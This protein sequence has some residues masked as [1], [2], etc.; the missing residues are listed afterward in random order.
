[1]F[2]PRAGMRAFLTSLCC[3]SAGCQTTST[4]ISALFPRHRTEVASEMPT[5][6]PEVLLSP[7]MEVQWQVQT[8]QNQPG[9][10]NA[11]HGMVGPDGTIDVGPY[12]SCQIAGLT[13]NQ[14]TGA[15]EKHLAE[16]IQSPN[17]RLSLPVQIESTEIAWR[18]ARADGISPVVPSAPVVAAE[19]V[20]T[21][22]DAGIQPVSRVQIIR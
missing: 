7:G 22:S 3:L 12:G 14:A 5:V 20:K 1:M 2:I 13:L 10:V 8:A 11:G 16:F 15:L 4:M 9:Q 19:S 17:V 18:P 21:Y 6:Q